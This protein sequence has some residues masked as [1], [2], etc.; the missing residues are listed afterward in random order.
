LPAPERVVAASEA[1][2]EGPRDAT[3]A[4]LAAIWAQVLGRPSVGVHEDFFELG[5]D[6]I[7]GIQVLAR[8]AQAGLHLTAKQLF[9]LPTVAQLAA[10]AGTAPAVAAEQGLVTGRV[11]LT[12][13]QRWFLDREPPAPHHFNQALRLTLRERIPAEVLERALQH[14]REHHDALRL[15]YTRDGQGAWRQEVTGLEGTLPLLRV[16][17]SGLPADARRAA[18][19]SH[20][21]RAQASL[22]LASGGVARAVLFEAGSEAPQEL[23]LIIH[24][25]VVDAVSWRVLVEDLLTACQQLRAGEPVRLPPKTLSF[26][27]WA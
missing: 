12:P 25:L 8:A 17:V 5:G 14:L 4:A 27:W 19:E 15:S 26:A 20:G 7:L 2:Q 18:E 6:S 13:I 1:V 10:V 21:A 24:H 3:E 16:D 23:V 11:E 22:E 9:E